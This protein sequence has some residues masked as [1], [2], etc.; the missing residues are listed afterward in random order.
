MSQY[1]DDEEVLQLFASEEDITNC[2]V[3]DERISEASNLLFL[4]FFVKN[5]AKIKSL[6]SSVLDLLISKQ[7]AV[8]GIYF[9]GEHSFLIEVSL[10]D[11]TKNWLVALIEE[12]NRHQTLTDKAKSDILKI[13]FGKFNHVIQNNIV[14]MLVIPNINPNFIN[15]MSSSSPFGLSD[16]KFL[17]IHTCNLIENPSEVIKK[18]ILESQNNDTLDK[19]FGIRIECNSFSEISV[20]FIIKTHEMK[21]S[22]LQT[23]YG[24]FGSL[25]FCSSTVHFIPDLQKE[26]FDKVKDD[27]SSVEWIWS[28]LKEVDILTCTISEQ[29]IALKIENLPIL[30]ATYNP[31]INSMAP[32]SDSINQ[33]TDA[34]KGTKKRSTS[35]FERLGPLINRDTVNHPANSKLSSDSSSDSEDQLTHKKMK[36]IVL[37]P[38][39]SSFGRTEYN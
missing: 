26:R 10:S 25:K 39:H 29:A 7:I 18:F 13:C 19:V 37:V 27:E 20:R 21:N 9:K 4:K 11:F 16:G 34:N 12:R 23:L 32:D 8:S 30:P 3:Q 33:L 28:I 5:T 17:N 31:E 6:T 24:I 2:E 22:L 38:Q 14:Y 35:I 15:C 1:M 36:S